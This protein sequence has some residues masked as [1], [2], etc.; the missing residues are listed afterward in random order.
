[1]LTIQ[2]EELESRLVLSSSSLSACVTLPQPSLASAAY[3]SSGGSEGSNAAT[4]VQPGGGSVATGPAQAQPV[5]NTPFAEIL[6]N[7]NLSA[8]QPTNAGSG[9]EVN[10]MP[11]EHTPA[12]NSS[13]R[14]NSP[15]ATGANTGIRIKTNWV[16]PR[17][18]P[19]LQGYSS[20]SGPAGPSRIQAPGWLF[21]PPLAAGMA[22]TPS[23]LG[24]HSLDRYEP[25]LRPIPFLQLG[26]LGQQGAPL[27]QLQL[28]ALKAGLL[29][30]VSVLGSH[31]QQTVPL[32]TPDLSTLEAGLLQFLA[33][34]GETG[35]QLA[36]G[37]DG[38]AFQMWVIAAVGAGAACALAYRQQRRSADGRATDFPPLPGCSLDDAR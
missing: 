20:A 37:L 32:P 29:Q 33:D 5:Q 36:I 22:T 8:G 31:G 34:L 9:N 27:P 7:V 38:A 18:L 11:T 26:P 35:S 1:M 25:H 14:T 24:L 21:P 16:Q 30:L 15:L 6:V 12:A 23:L 19:S 28:S 3:S 13:E 17:Y 4:S 10:A 2:L